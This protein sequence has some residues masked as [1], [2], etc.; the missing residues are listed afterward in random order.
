MLVQFFINSSPSSNGY[1]SLSISLF[2]FI[3]Y[4]YSSC[5]T[6]INQKVFL[7]YYPVVTYNN[8]I[9]WYTKPLS[10]KRKISDNFFL[11]VLVPPLGSHYAKLQSYI[12]KKLREKNKKNIDALHTS[13]SEN[14]GYSPNHFKNKKKESQHYTIF[15]S[16]ILIVITDKPK[17]KLLKLN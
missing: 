7:Y 6:F 17:Y 15:C 14:E 16:Y 5:Y 3:S 8:S 9:L 11:F 1:V 12:V 13:L 2:S 10:K 4:F